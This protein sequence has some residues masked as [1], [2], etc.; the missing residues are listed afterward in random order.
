M[1]EHRL[2][3]QPRGLGKDRAEHINNN[4]LYLRRDLRPW[5]ASRC[6][7]SR[8]RRKGTFSRCCHS[9]LHP[10]RGGHGCREQCGCGCPFSEC[11][12]WE[13]EAQGASRI[14]VD[15]R[16]LASWVLASSIP[17]C[18]G[19]LSVCHFG[20]A[21]CWESWWFLSCGRLLRFSCRPRARRLQDPCPGLQALR[22]PRG[23]SE[24]EEF[25]HRC[26]GQA[27]SPRPGVGF[28]PSGTHRPLR[29]E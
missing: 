23:R 19:L 13:T 21:V 5:C 29:M 14:R 25:H 9:G 1:T 27:G 4:K 18:D 20:A 12:N 6:V 11:P 28:C 15:V 10:C 16:V 26:P 22:G 2:A 8:S 24:R 17:E 3:W 7:I